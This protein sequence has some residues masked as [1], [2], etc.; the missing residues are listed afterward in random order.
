MAQAKKVQPVKKSAGGSSLKDFFVPHEGNN[1]RPRALRPKRLWFHVGAALAIKGLLII[2]VSSY[3]MI[4][5]MA[6]DVFT[7]EEGKIITLTNDLRKSLSLGALTENTKLDIAA[8]KKVQ[9]MFINQYFAHVSPKNLDLDYFLQFASYKNYLTVGE[10]LAMGYD[11][12]ADVMAAW[13]K[14]P[15]HYSNLVDPNFTQI[16]V[17]LAAGTYKDQ[18]TVLAAQYFG[19]PQTVSQIAEPTVKVKKSIEKRS[20]LGK[21]TVLGATETIIKGEA[22]ST[23]ASVQ[24]SLKS[25]QVIV[26][27]PAGNKDDQ[28]VRV[29][30]IFP[31]GTSMVHAQVLGNDIEMSPVGDAQSETE[32]TGQS[33]IQNDNKSITPPSISFVDPSGRLQRVDVSNNNIQPQKASV[34][35][36]YL[37][38]KNSPNEDLG[39]IFNISSIYFKIILGLAIFTILLNI[40]IALWHKRRPKLI[41]SSFFLV[42]FLALMI[43]F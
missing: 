17:S 30:A 4:A 6:P 7:A 38:F 12:A 9:D 43:I 33:I 26:S 13:E 35:S 20:R 37:L 41:I 11:N 18:D 36:Q 40:L 21:K 28:V 16:G 1:Y 19:L 8:D 34:T 27:Q 24:T 31:A 23:M 25:A 3:P 10:N 32:W 15:T 5:W 22:T 39:Q 42:L 29:S 14:S 2:L